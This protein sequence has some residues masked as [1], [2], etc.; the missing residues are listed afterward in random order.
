MKKNSFNLLVFFSVALFGVGISTIPNSSKEENYITKENTTITNKGRIKDVSLGDY[1]SAV[2][3]TD[4]LGNDHLY[5]WGYNGDGQLGI[6]TKDG[7][8]NYIPIEIEL[9]M[10]GKIKDVDLGDFF[11]SMVM[12]DDD[13]KEYL[14]T[15]GANGSGQL[16]YEGTTYSPALVETLPIENFKIEEL[17]MGQ[18]CSGVLLEDEDEIEHVY[19]WGS[20][21]S[22]ET[23][24]SEVKW[25]PREIVFPEVEDIK[26]LE[27]R[28]VTSS[29][30]VTDKDGIDHL[31]TWGANGSGQLGIGSFDSNSHPV[32]NEV[33][34][35]V[36]TK[37]IKDVALGNMSGIAL[38]ND[39]NEDLVFTW[40]GNNCGQLGIGESPDLSSPVNIN[41]STDEQI[42]DVGSGASTTDIVTIDENGNYHLYMWGYNDYGQIGSSEAGKIV[43][44]PVE[45]NV[46]E[47]EEIVS[48]NFG[49]KSSSAVLKDNLNNYQLYMWG[50]NRNGGL[51]ISNEEDDYNSINSPREITT[52]WNEEY[53]TWT[54]PIKRNEENTFSFNIE[55]TE[56]IKQNKNNVY[57]YNE[58]HEQVG[59]A[60][61]SNQDDLNFVFDGEITDSS[62]DGPLYWSDD[63]GETLNLIIEEVSFESSSSTRWLI[64]LL[65]LLILLIIMIIVTYFVVRKK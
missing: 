38:V 3:I 41:F 25:E 43:K 54:T 5:M 34:F 10:E 15:W 49:Y 35:P 6:G 1:H 39:G 64:W 62:I 13:G 9:P 21:A 19:M 56:E 23:G 18:T 33:T 37:E 51:G 4:P 8:F 26:Q 63:G 57:L 11:S 22:G 42:V 53:F 20:K 58:K 40:G 61:L 32:P 52:I 27:V 36:E 50:N 65:I 29:A 30:I 16:G 45:I 55:L 47:G 59:K 44:S 28:E 7:G 46:P 2:V 60:E 14:Y 48:M 24:E 17:D 12:V 31:Y